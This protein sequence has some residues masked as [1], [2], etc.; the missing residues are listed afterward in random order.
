MFLFWLMDTYVVQLLRSFFYVTET[1]F[2]KNRLFFYRKSVWSKLQSI[3]IRYHTASLS[4]SCLHIQRHRHPQYTCQPG[5]GPCGR[6]LP[7]AMD[8]TPCFL[9]CE[10]ISWIPKVGEL[11]I[12]GLHLVSTPEGSVSSVGDHRGPP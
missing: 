4:A 1:T 12:N 11:F 9:A 8:W 6:G 5:H 7:G 2:Q 10:S 3:G